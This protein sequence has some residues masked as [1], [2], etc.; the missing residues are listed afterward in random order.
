MGNIQIEEAEHRLSSRRPV[1][2]TLESENATEKEEN[3]RSSRRPTPPSAP[4][5]AAKLPRSPRRHDLHPLE[6]RGL[7]AD[8]PV[9][10]GAL[11]EEAFKTVV[12]R[13]SP[14]PQ[15]AAPPAA[16]PGSGLRQVR[17]RRHRVPPH[18]ERV[19]SPPRRQ[20]GA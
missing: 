16:S 2:W 4:T 1:G 14:R 10:E 5:A 7:L 19:G 15:S 12:T 13:P 17:R 20:K 8:L 3:D 18:H 6:T 11:D 9:K